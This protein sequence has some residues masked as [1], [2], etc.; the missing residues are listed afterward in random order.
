MQNRISGT[1]HEKRRVAITSAGC[2]HHIRRRCATK[3][4]LPPQKMFM[5]TTNTSK[6]APSLSGRKTLKRRR[7]TRRGGRDLI[8]WTQ[9]IR[10]AEE[11]A[12]VHT[13]SRLSERAA[14]LRE[15]V[16]EKRQHDPA[17][18]E[19]VEFAGLVAE[20]VFRTNGFRLFDVQV[21]ALGAG[22]SDAIVEMQ[23]GEGKTVVTGSIAAIKTLSAP[24][25][26]VGTTNTYL[27]A[28]DLESLTG[29]FDLLG[30][31]Y[32]L[33][34]EESDEAASRRAYRNQIVYG[35]GY[36]YGFDF[37]RDQMNL[38][39]NRQSKLGLA[40][41]NRIRGKDP[42]RNMIQSG[43]F[44]V[45]L[46]DEAD[47][48]MID[49]AMTPLIISMPAKNY[50]DP[51]PYLL[52]KKIAADMVE[53]I[54]YTIEFP[55]K[56]ITLKDSA[57]QYAHD[58][59]AREK[60]LQLFRPWRTYIINAIRAERTFQ[61][62]VEYAVVDGEVQIVDQYTGRIQPDRTWQDGLH[63]AVEAKE[64]VTIQPGRESTTQITRQRYLQLYDQL[65][66]LTG[67]AKSVEEEFRTVYNCTT[68]EIPTNRASLREIQG[69]RF[70]VSLSAKLNAIA[71]DVK[72][73]HRNGQPI[74][75]G[76]KTIR[77]SNEVFDVL[78]ANG[79]KPTL[80]NGVQDGEE[81]DIVGAAGVA[82]AI[83]IATNM[84][85]R[86]TDIK[87]DQA[88]LEAGGLHVIGV[89]PNSSKRIDRQ[90]VGRAAR[91]GQPGSAQFFAA[92]DDDLFVENESS[93]QKQIKRRERSGGE[94]TDFT[95]E[96]A[97]LQRSIEMRNYKQ[98]QDMILRDRWMDSV[99]EA[100]EKD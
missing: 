50:E 6:K 28:R 53:N 74:L 57:S 34:P 83:T 58:Q 16:Q 77:E 52:A 92:A 51:M 62:D 79:L 54:D 42:L 10:E 84:A 63:Q 30:I 86:G 38:R 21:S 90:L 29:M 46:I 69:T 22:A 61:R 93:L 26:H 40:T 64:N 31:S 98:R 48:V 95:R 45:A 76:T 82:G 75:I 27:A 2:T 23:T 24:S 49:E 15:A 20:A 18:A 37:L 91:Q 1:Q 47:S 39:D 100:I 36:Q 65:A 78:L 25:V 71:E 5:A 13:D 3:S 4:T 73:R 85:G 43:E 67:T 44:H 60:K 56:K 96:L 8:R 9:Q 35:P 17:S 33:L 80:L 7:W 94:S 59:V 88:A 12:K 66:G 41:I 89:S 68:I 11:K 99:R 70:F 97:L 72:V 87:P 32:G 19:V 14:E 55:S 81:A